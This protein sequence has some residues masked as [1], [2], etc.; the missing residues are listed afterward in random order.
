MY[1]VSKQGVGCARFPGVYARVSA[2]Y[3]WINEQL[4]TLSEQPPASCGISKHPEDKARIRIDFQYNDNSR[5]T[6][7]ELNDRTKAKTE[8][9]SAAG[10]VKIDNVLVSSYVNLK[11]GP[12]EFKMEGRGTLNTFKEVSC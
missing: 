6:S 3:E 2:A 10:S 4:C 5:D 9:F 1:F 7:W 11:P 8:A 12:Y